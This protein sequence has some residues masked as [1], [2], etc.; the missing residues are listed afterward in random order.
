M[1]YHYLSNAAIVEMSPV[2]NIWSEICSLLTIIY[3]GRA[4]S[5]EECTKIPYDRGIHCGAIQQKALNYYVQYAN[6]IYHKRIKQ[7]WI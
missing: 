6:T 7:A 4:Y 5:K 2:G 1:S 3:V